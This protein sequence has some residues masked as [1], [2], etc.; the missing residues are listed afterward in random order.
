MGK[1]FNNS[2]KNNKS[3]IIKIAIIAIFLVLIIIILIVVNNKQP[4]ENPNITLKNNLTIP[5]NGDKPDVLDY[6]TKFDNYDKNDVIIT[7]PE[8]FDT[9]KAGTYDVELKIAGKTYITKVKVEDNEPPEVI[10]QDLEID[11]GKKYYAE[12]FVTM[13]TDNSN[14]ECTLN[15]YDMS[16]DQEGNIID[17]SSYTEPGT[18]LIK[19]VATDVNKNST[20]PISVM[21]TIKD[22]NGNIKGDNT[23]PTP[24]QECN[25]GD[26][27]YNDAIYDFP[28][29][30]IVGDEQNNCALN[31]DLWD[32]EE[33]QKPVVQL[34]KKDLEKLKSNWEK[35]YD[36]K[37]PD[38]AKTYVY[39]N[40]KAIW[41]NDNKGLVGYGIHIKFY[42]SPANVSNVSAEENL[43][44]E[45][46]IL[47]DGSRE[48][49]QNPY[50]FE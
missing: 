9:S 36:E 44:A 11:Y 34:F 19:I 4:A 12:D 25:Y 16:K 15:Y 32:D 21:L 37:Y 2:V 6:F 43:I 29:A 49:I 35:I 39:Q 20:E 28:I 13:C 27:A 23:T 30:I 45:Y 42:A 17:Y 26:L 24:T 1:F 3:T 48:Y 22:E 33:T 7:Y 5:I 46:Y 10:T 38:G 50:N 41:N 47:A 14:K 31:R 8:N 18:Y 40:F